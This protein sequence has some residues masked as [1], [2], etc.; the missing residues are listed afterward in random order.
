MEKFPLNP[1]CISII[2]VVKFKFDVLS[3]CHKSKVRRKKKETKSIFWM[4]IKFHGDESYA[5]LI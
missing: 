3:L 5:L 1:K 4:E 2:F